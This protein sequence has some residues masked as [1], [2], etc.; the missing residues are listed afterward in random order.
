MSEKVLTG[1]KEE[2]VGFVGSRGLRRDETQKGKLRIRFDLGCG[3]ND[4]SDNKYPTWRHCVAYGTLAAKLKVIRPGSLLT[5]L[6][7]VS[8]EA[9]LDEYYKPQKD[10]AGKIVTNEFLICRNVMITE[11]VKLQS[12]LPLAVGQAL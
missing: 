8:T 6:G 4:E 12:T 5:V 11:H 7:W 3:V 2:A 9:R 1:I 10:N